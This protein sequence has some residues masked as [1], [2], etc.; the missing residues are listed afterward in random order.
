MYIENQEVHKG[1]EQ[2]QKD[3]NNTVNQLDFIASWV[4]PHLISVWCILFKSMW[5]IQVRPFA[6]F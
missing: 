1:F 4:I 5:N 2:Q 3:L 6:G